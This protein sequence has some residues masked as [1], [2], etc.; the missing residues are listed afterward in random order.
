MKAFLL[1]AGDGTRL[2]PL[3]NDTPKCLVPIRGVPMLNIW[4][5]ICRRSGIDEVL[6]NT[7]AHADA[8]RAALG[9]YSGIS[10][11]VVEEV[12]LLGSAGTI[13]A[14]RDWIAD[15]PYFWVLY[16]DVLTNMDLSPMLAL[17]Q[18]AGLVATIGV[19]PIKSDPTQCG[20]VEFGDDLIVR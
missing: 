11:Q 13:A 14:N 8:V 6:I 20:V 1:A 15:E 12:S 9:E 3:T 17:H 7:H 4:L 16:A 18:K 19:H 5:D 2:R 10:I